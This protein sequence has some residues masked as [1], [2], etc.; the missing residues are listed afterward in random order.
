LIVEKRFNGEF[1]G[2]KNVT[3]VPYE[4]RLID[5]SLLSKADIE[6]IDAYHQ[7]VFIKYDY[8]MLTGSRFM[9]PWHPFSKRKTTPAV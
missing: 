1:L 7:R 6:H 3:V 5:V 2:F 4:R 8:F 9:T